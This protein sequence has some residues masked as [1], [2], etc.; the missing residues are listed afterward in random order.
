MT[1]AH[2]SQDIAQDYD[3]DERLD[4]TDLSETVC[5]F[6]EYLVVEPCYALVSFSDGYVSRLMQLEQGMTTEEIEQAIDEHRQALQHI[7]ECVTTPEWWEH[8]GAITALKEHL[9]EPESSPPH[10]PLV[11]FQEMFLIQSSSLT[12]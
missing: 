4:Y 10:L 6:W 8:V 5:Q 11:R 12:N 1:L 7:S 2:R 9:V 3:I